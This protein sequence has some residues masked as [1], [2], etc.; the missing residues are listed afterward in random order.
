MTELAEIRHSLDKMQDR[1][2]EVQR[3]LGRIEGDVSGL[4]GDVGE[5]RL[6]IAAERI[7]AAEQAAANDKRL[8]K[9]ERRQHWWAGAAAVI[10]AILG[11]VAPRHWPS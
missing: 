7:R 10:G 6:E 11:S 9:V 5:L 2:A 4:R 1:G 3:S 8:R